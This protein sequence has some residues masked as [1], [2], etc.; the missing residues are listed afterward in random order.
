M[1]PALEAMARALA[2]KF[3]RDS[4]PDI[5]AGYV[6][7]HWPKWVDDATASLRALPAEFAETVAAILG[8]TT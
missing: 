2:D 4:E 7:K 5:R 1:T 8:E 3:A 6:D